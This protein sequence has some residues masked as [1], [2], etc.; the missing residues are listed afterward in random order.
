MT[1]NLAPE[2]VCQNQRPAAGLSLLEKS[3]WFMGSLMTV[4]A[5]PAAT[6]GSAALIEMVG[7]PGLE[8]PFHSQKRRR[9]VL[10]DRGLVE[11]LPR[12]RRADVEGRRVGVPASRRATYL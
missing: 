10:A 6:N 2:E 11:G 7:A 4:H 8:P 12:S 3:V 9:D 5:D 1:A